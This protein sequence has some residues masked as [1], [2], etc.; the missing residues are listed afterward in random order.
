M[1]EG[2]TMNLPPLDGPDLHWVLKAKPN[3]LDCRS[4][5]YTAHI[6]NFHQPRDP[7]EMGWFILF[8]VPCETCHPEEKGQYSV[9]DTLQMFKDLTGQ[10]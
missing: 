8:Y 10:K 2:E 9:S 7:K 4:R 1:L 3:C 6:L 5:G